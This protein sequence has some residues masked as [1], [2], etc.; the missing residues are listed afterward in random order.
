[1]RD[2]VAVLSAE[3]VAQKDNWQLIDDLWGGTTSMRLAKTRRL[4]QEEMESDAAYTLRLGRSTLFNAFKQTVKS[5]VGKPFAKPIAIGDDM[6]QRLQGFAEDIDLDGTHLDVFARRL[7]ELVVRDGIAHILVDF[8]KTDG[9]LSL[10]AERSQG[11]R[12]YFCAIDA[13]QV[14]GWKSQRLGGRDVLTQVRIKESRSEDDPADE[15]GARSVDRIRVLEPGRF[16]VYERAQGVDDSATWKL[17][18]EGVTKNM[19]QVPLV[20]IYARRTG[21]LTA[22]PPLLDLAHLNVE[23]WASRSDQANILHVARVPILLLTGFSPKDKI[24]IGPF[25]ALRTQDTN[26][27]ARFVEHSGAAIGAG[28]DDIDGIENRMRIMGL[29]MLVENG[30]R[31]TATQRVLDQGE[32]ES[33]LGAYVR[34]LGDGLENAFRLAATWLG[35]PDEAGSLSV[36]RDFGISMRDAQEAGTLLK[37]RLAGEITQATFLRELQKR[38]L[39]GDEVDVAEEEAITTA[40]REALLAFPSNNT[41]SG[42]S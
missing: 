22:D 16:R 15:F 23:H 11:V 14:I 5:L 2:K 1:M 13:R 35:T 28:K 4:P 24:A 18:D 20:T 31:V 40:E 41:G 12:P 27:G 42:A 39:V 25:R 33:E 29:E 37:M 19:P 26:A 10:F 6:S 7:F 21:A 36:H 32:R 9:E 34:E 3:Y 38:G 30:Q 8:P 17:V